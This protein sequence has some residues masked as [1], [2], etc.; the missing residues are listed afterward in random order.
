MAQ[1]VKE[2]GELAN[3]EVSVDRWPGARRHP[4]AQAGLNV[5]FKLGC[6]FETAC[7]FRNADRFLLKV[8]VFSGVAASL[9]K[10]LP[11]SAYE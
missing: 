10:L 2:V 3:I 5:R 6:G 9:V 1:M 8:I 11:S 4:L 7:V